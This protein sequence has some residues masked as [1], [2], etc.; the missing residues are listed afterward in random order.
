MLEEEIDESIIKSIIKLL[1]DIQCWT[2]KTRPHILSI[3]QPASIFI[4]SLLFVYL[5]LIP[6]N[7]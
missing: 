2:F 7:I 6:Q 3:M 1:F 4:V 5:F